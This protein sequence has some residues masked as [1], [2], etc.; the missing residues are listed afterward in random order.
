MDFFCRETHKICW[1]LGLSVPEG[2]SEAY[3]EIEKPD[4]TLC[5]F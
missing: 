2:D 3:W 4:L 5:G 1:S